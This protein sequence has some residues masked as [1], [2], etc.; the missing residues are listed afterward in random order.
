MIP[1][2]NLEVYFKVC[3]TPHTAHVCHLLIEST[4]QIGWS[5]AFVYTACVACIKLSILALYKR[6]FATKHM[7]VAVN[8]VTAMI[9]LWAVS[10]WVVGAVQCIP[11]RKF[12]NPSVEGSCID[13]TP[14]YYGMQI[15]N[16]ITDLIVLAM[17][18]KTVWSLPIPTTQRLLLSGVFIVG[19]LFVA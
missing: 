15:P 14:F 6:L 12:W 19:G 11:V 5:N 7:V 13:P 4:H 18:M 9:V 17:P 2:K 3:L 8:V 1:Q 16:I 10:I